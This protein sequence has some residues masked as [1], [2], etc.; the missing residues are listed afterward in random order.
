[1]PA[2]RKRPNNRKTS[3]PESTDLREVPFHY[4][5]EEHSFTAPA[6]CELNGIMGKDSSESPESEH[7]S[8]TF[9]ENSLRIADGFDAQADD[10]VSPCDPSVPSGICGFQTVESS[11]LRGDDSA[12]PSSGE[13]SGG[14]DGILLES[15]QNSDGCSNAERSE[16][17]DSGEVLQLNLEPEHGAASFENSDALELIGERVPSKP[18]T[19]RAESNP[20]L[21][22]MSLCLSQS[23]FEFPLDP[24]DVPPRTYRAPPLPPRHRH[25]DIHRLEEPPPLP[26]RIEKERTSSHSGVAPTSPC[27][28]FE[29]VTFA[30]AL[31]PPPL[32]PRTYSPIHMQSGDGGAS[33]SG[34][35]LSLV[36]TEDSTSFDS[37]EA[38]AGSHESSLSDNSSGERI[39]REPRRSS[40]L[41]VDVPRREH[42]KQKVSK[43]V[44]LSSL[45]NVSSQTLG[46][47]RQVPEFQIPNIDNIRA[48]DSTSHRKDVVNRNRSASVEAS[49]DML[50]SVDLSS[51]DG[52]TPPPI[53]RLRSVDSLRS[54][55]NS[56]PPPPLVERHRTSERDMAVNRMETPPPVNR[57]RHFDSAPPTVERHKNYDM[58][59]SSDKHKQLHSTQSIGRHRN[60]EA[61]MADRHRTFDLP[62]PFDRQRSV[63]SIPVDRLRNNDLS[64]GQPFDMPPSLPP[65]VTRQKSNE[66]NQS[67]HRSEVG[68][69]QLHEYSEQM[70]SGI[71]GQSSVENHLSVDSHN[72][73]ER[74]HSNESQRTLDRQGSNESQL[75]NSSLGSASFA[76]GLTPK[77]SRDATLAPK[78]TERRSLSPAVRRIVEPPEMPMEGASE[79]LPA[80][81][82]RGTGSDGTPPPRPVT[83]PRPGVPDRRDNTPSPPIIYPRG[84]V[85][86]EEEKHQNRQNIHQHLKNWTQKQKER[87]N[88]SFGSDVSGE[89]E[90]PSPMSEPRSCDNWVLF[91]DNATPS[92][93]IEASPARRGGAE[94]VLGAEGGVLPGHSAISNSGRLS[95][96]PS[97]S[98]VWQLRHGDDQ[99]PS[100]SDVGK[101]VSP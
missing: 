37:M 58:N 92:N 91:D 35:S 29:N 25:S 53:E 3:L 31:S 17:S 40:G 24:P 22:G 65:I 67:E 46:K 14:S 6:L 26:P 51:V 71:E 33:G 85:L 55:T 12:L 99:P 73:V 96:T 63:D 48:M 70:H 42:H 41:G 83:P 64:M 27:H 13:N 95:P 81:P 34:G 47:E 72:I 93:S 97:N 87:A 10:I 4:A 9:H 62:P 77:P 36:S 32:P 88:T 5:N 19:P 78:Q 44:G 59:K 94:H 56:S 38:F 20:L 45:S 1:M 49:V 57:N 80:I 89:L 43:G 15:V 8:S 66:P 100:V 2:K 16:F 101:W 50:Q 82:Q 60:R 21:N 23:D 90:L 74:Q 76:L 84:R 11:G 86:S 39:E 30:D 75:S 68:D 54:E 69:N 98:V 61:A 28:T 52:D 79:G 18:S 7:P